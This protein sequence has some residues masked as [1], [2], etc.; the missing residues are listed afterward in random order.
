MAFSDTLKERVRKWGLNEVQKY[1]WP[2]VAEEVEGFYK[3]IFEIN[4]G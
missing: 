1:R 4:K 2:K 3:R